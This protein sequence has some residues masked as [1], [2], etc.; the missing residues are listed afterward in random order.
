[1]LEG[2]LGDGVH[3]NAAG[4]K[5]M[6]EVWYDAIC[7][8]SSVWTQYWSDGKKKSESHWRNMFADG[9]AICWNQAGKEI[10]RVNFT[11]GLMDKSAKPVEGPV[12]IQGINQDKGGEAGAAKEGENCYTDRAYAIS[13]LP[14]E[15][16]GGK[17]VR[18]ANNDDS[19]TKEDYL[20]LELSADSTVYVCYWADANALPEWLKKEG[21]KKLEGQAKVKIGGKDCAYNVF[22][23]NVSKG[24]LVL[25]GNERERTNAISMYFVV[26]KTAK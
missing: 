10:S 15:L 25:G 7:G 18:T 2:K 4:C 22:A 5:A 9:L 3:P 20:P 26:I 12:A 17:L 14:P 13:S 23:R 19:S 21:W 6:A 24:R 1:M 16:Q 8:D 11:A